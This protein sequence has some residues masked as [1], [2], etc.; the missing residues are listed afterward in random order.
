MYAP[1]YYIICAYIYS[2]YLICSLFFLLPVWHF[3]SIQNTK[4]RL[5]SFGSSQMAEIRE[6]KETFW[7]HITSE[8]DNYISDGWTACTFRITRCLFMCL[9]ET[10]CHI[11]FKCIHMY[12]CM[13]IPFVYLN[14]KGERCLSV[15]NHFCVNN[16]YYA[17]IKR[18][19][20]RINLV[21]LSFTL[22][23]FLFI[24]QL[25]TDTQG[26]GVLLMSA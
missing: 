24:C 11:I 23:C 17:W 16:K 21:T 25:L 3:N 2:P 9:L 8:T 14:Y 7:I 4:T 19:N 26:R 5:I 6:R 12:L 10:H 15:R 20:Y 22:I 18:L 13:H 1:Y